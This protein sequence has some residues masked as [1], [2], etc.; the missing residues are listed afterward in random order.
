MASIE[1]GIDVIQG[2]LETG[3]WAFAILASVGTTTDYKELARL[4]S[5]FPL[6]VL[7]VTGIA[8]LFT[9]NIKRGIEFRLGIALVFF[10][11][12]T[13]SFYHFWSV[14][15]N[16]S[17]MFTLSIPLFYFIEKRRGGHKDRLLFFSNNYHIDFVSSKSNCNSKSAGL[18]N[19]GHVKVFA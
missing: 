17:R 3:L 5:R 15:E 16:V 7:L 18:Y 12:S 14:Y 10:M 1:R 8:I 13:A 2:D 11:V 19:L 9:G 6:L 4:L